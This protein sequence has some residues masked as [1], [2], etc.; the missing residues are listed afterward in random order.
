M[1]MVSPTLAASIALCTVEK[2][3]PLV[4]TWQAWQTPPSATAPVQHCPLIGVAPATP[5]VFLGWCF[6]FLRFFLASLAGV[7]PQWGTSARAAAS[8][9]R[10]EVKT[11]C[12]N[13]PH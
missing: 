11:E 12:L 1:T 13:A 3:Q 5:H 9:A 10:R 7:P 4:Q 8:R 6:R 2:R